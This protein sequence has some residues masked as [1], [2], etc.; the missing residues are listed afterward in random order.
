MLV[1]VLIIISLLMGALGGFIIARK[2]DTH[3]HELQAANDRIT[4]LE[5][6]L[7]LS[8]IPF[9]DDGSLEPFDYASND[10]ALRDLSGQGWNDGDEADLWDDTSLLDAT[11]P[12]NADPVVVAEFEGGQLLS[13]EVV[14]VYNDRLTTLIFSG[15]SADDVAED[16]LNSVLEELA[17]DKIIAL[18]AAELKLTELS[19]ADLAQIRQQASENYEAQLADTMAFSEDNDRESAAKVLEEESGVTLESVTESLKQSWWTQKYF[20]YIVKDVTVSDEEVQAHYDALLSRQ[21]AT[22]GDYPEDFE[23]DHLTGQLIVFHPDGYRAVRDILIP[24]D[25]ESADAAAGLSEQIELGTAAED[26]QKQLDAL[27]APLEKKAEEVQKKLVDGK[28]FSELMDEYGCDQALKDE[29][30][31]SEGYYIN[32]SSFVNSQEYVEGSMMLEQPGQVSTPLRSL[33]GV[34]LVEYIGE[35]APGAVALDDVREAVTADALK[36]KQTEYYEQQRQALLDAAQVK[37]Y[38][39][40]LR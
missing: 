26:A 36:A 8:G 3:I 40:R 34:H 11:L 9:E 27:Y 10:D 25:D 14:P 7:T 19:D 29:P 33:S 31:R 16:T 30:L 5:N 12:E 4:E 38:P 39:E 1:I 37:Y 6:R 24:F 2:T 17:G 23:Y 21:E 13:N 28:S 22:Y 15:H 18:R 20:D 35:V 32:G